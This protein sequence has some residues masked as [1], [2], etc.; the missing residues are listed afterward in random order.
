MLGVNIFLVFKAEA[1]KEPK[2]H[3]SAKN[4]SN[5]YAVR[6]LADYFIS[7]FTTFERWVHWDCNENEAVGLNHF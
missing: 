2:K 6:C 7:N 4:I 5:G 3:S 1:P